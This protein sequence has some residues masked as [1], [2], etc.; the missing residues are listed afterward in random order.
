MA[1]AKKEL[2]EFL[3]RKV[4]V[5]CAKITVDCQYD[6]RNICPEYILKLNYSE[7]EFNDFLKSLDFE[8]SANYGGQK[9]SGTVW[10]EDGT[11]GTHQGCYG[12]EWW[13]HNILPDIPT[14][15]L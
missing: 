8:Y 12:S 1:N 6:N 7:Q 15:C 13:E 11:W 14:E 10:F 9:L 3:K 4:K 5:K 2:E